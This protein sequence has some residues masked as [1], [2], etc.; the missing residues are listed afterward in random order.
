MTGHIHPQLITHF[1]CQ[2]CKGYFLAN[3]MHDETR[4]PRP[5]SYIVPTNWECESVFALCVECNK[6]LDEWLKKERL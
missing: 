5:V 1:Q 4:Q 6:A 2:K 3:T